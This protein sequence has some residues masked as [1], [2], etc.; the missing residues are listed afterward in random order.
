MA[1]KLA[2]LEA[3][4][5][6]HRPITASSSGPMAAFVALYNHPEALSVTTYV[7][8]WYILGALAAIT[9][10]DLIRLY[11]YPMAWSSIQFLTSYWSVYTLLYFQ[12]KRKPTAGTTFEIAYTTTLNT[13]GFVFM[14]TS[15]LY[16]KIVG[17]ACLWFT[18]TCLLFL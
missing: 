13:F 16:G 4:D 10:K 12:G 9:T 15:L 11:P 2:N 17:N 5:D 1:D 8:V 18:I 6:D 7:L 14:N 3:G